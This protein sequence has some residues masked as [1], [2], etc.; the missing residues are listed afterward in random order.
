LGARVA[1]WTSIALSVLGLVD[2]ARGDSPL[3]L[4]LVALQAVVAA[5]LLRRWRGAWGLAFAVASVDTLLGS[6]AMIGGVVTTS[7]DALAAG[8]LVTTLAVVGLL[9]LARRGVRS[10]LLRRRASPVAGRGAVAR[11]DP[12]APR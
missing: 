5:A 10:S 2:L 9:A 3:V 11:L 4:A 6:L 1:A 8:L 7:G 12:P